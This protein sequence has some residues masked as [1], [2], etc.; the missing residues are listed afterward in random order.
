MIKQLFENNYDALLEIFN[1]VN[2]GIYITD[3]DGRTILVNDESCR[4]GGLTR[5]EV[6]GKT[7]K[8]L[9]E[10]GFVK[11]SVTLKTIESGKAEQLVQ[12]LGDG[13][14][15][16]VTSMPKIEDGIIEY[17]V[18]TERDITETKML[19]DVL[20]E[21]EETTEKYLE[22][23]EYLKNRNF[24]F[25][26]EVVAED[27]HSQKTIQQAVRV[28]KH[29]T[30]VLL[31]GES[32]TGKEI[33]AN[34]IYRHSPRKG[35]PFIKINC[36]AIP[37]NLLE[38]ELFGYEK[39][40]FTGADPAGKTGYF[41]LA[42]GGT[43]FLDEIGEM[44][45]HLQSKLLR[46]LQ[47]KEIFKVGGTT[48]IGLDVRLIAAT[49]TDLT[50]AIKQG[51]FREDL[52][53]RLSVMPIEILPLRKR[54][55]DI[56]PLAK[57]FADRYNKEYKLKKQIEPNAIHSLEEYSWPGNVRELQNVIERCVLSFD[58]NT[59]NRFQIE[60]VLYP[61]IPDFSEGWTLDSDKS[62]HQII[63]EYEENI[64]A[65]ALQQFK[66]PA[67]AARKLGI[68]KS[69]MSRKMSRYNLK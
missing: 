55:G 50:K 47:E 19:R 54:K 39:G 15:V 52:Y 67:E 63:Q 9:E 51:E 28:A 34:L 58:G 40:A 38:A 17:V 53:Y 10:E 59:I 41:Q 44:P 56:G 35:R 3:G 33:Y 68:D 5:E 6:M 1:C 61:D 4:T 66:T 14:R 57:Y 60:R 20:H 2:V 21:Q 13:G 30:T 24:Y 62:L 7:M 25:L 32:G 23:I 64:L 42:N 29:N 69:T 46:A 43:L 26:G 27:I 36:A 48:P 8:V 12:E 31:T 16:F 22:E 45:I 37:E 11:E 49:N 65:S 18:T